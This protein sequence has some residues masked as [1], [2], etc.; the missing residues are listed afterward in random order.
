MAF[1]LQSQFVNMIFLTEQLNLNFLEGSIIEFVATQPPSVY[2]YQKALARLRILMDTAITM[3]PEGTTQSSVAALLDYDAATFNNT[4][5]AKKIVHLIAHARQRSRVEGALSNYR[6][7][8]AIINHLSDS[9]EMVEMALPA[10]EL[11]L[12]GPPVSDDEMT[13]QED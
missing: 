4:Y 10:L 5:A 6:G 2:R 9:L 11:E 3:T 1:L 13:L 12:E 8:A 7:A